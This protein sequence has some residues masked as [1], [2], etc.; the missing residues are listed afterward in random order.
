MAVQRTKT[1]KNKHAAS[2]SGISNSKAASK[3]PAMDGIVRPKRNK[4]GKTP[5]TI[6]K[7]VKEKGA[8]GKKNKRKSYTA[9]QLGIPT[10]NMITPVGVEKPKGK[11]KGKV[12]VDDR[13]RFLIS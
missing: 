7:Q 4:S 10:L 13:V 11:K 5:A 6:S 2:K 9:E 12:F 8:Q 1:V 3:R